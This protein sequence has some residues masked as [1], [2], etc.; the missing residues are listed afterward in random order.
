[1][2]DFFNANVDLT[3]RTDLS[4]SYEDLAYGGS[5]AA[6]IGVFKKDTMSGDSKKIVL[7]NS[8]NPGQSATMGQ[9]VANGNAGPNNGLAGRAG[10]TVP[11]FKCYGVSP[12][13]PLDQDAFTKGD[14]AVVAVLLDESKTA[15]DSAKMQLDRALASDGSGTDFTIVSHTGSGPQY[16][17]VLAE[18]AQI[19]RV[20]LNGTY[21]SK[22]T[23]FAASFDVGATASFQVNN[24]TPST[25]SITVTA[26]N[27]WAPTDGHVAGIMG[28]VQASTS[29]VTWPGIPAWIVPFASRPISQS[30]NFFGQNRSV[31]ETK[32]AGSA[33]KCAGGGAN[34]LEGIL[35]LAND[36]A[37]VPGSNPD[38]VLGSYQTKGKIVAFLQTQRRYNEGEIQG[39]GIEV[40]Y[41]TVKISG[42]PKGDM[43]FMASSNWS[44]TM[45]AVLDKSTWELYYPEG[46]PGPFAPVGVNGNPVQYI[47]GTDTAQAAYRCSAV[48]G[49]TAPGW[50]G[51]LSHPA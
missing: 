36:I 12:A 44:S 8:L 17:L 1:M 18:K 41:K 20:V 16:T 33:R 15:M 21:Q 7:K 30:D 48:V 23:P 25:M 43:D 29:V 19:N 37:D 47:P 39:S 51:M 26:S 49:C 38:T 50:N 35:D 2:A 13:I 28:T 24:I 34:I 10:F 42:G 32:L 14:N 40:F 3:L 11:P 46:Q 5:Y 9:A 4:K 45:T 6:I 22:A 31:D 27:S